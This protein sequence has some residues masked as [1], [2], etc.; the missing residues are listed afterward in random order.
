M[1]IMNE[2]KTAPEIVA[3]GDVEVVSYTTQVVAGTN[4]KISLKHAAGMS[5]V[6]VFKALPHAGEGEAVKVVS[7]THVATKKNVDQASGAAVLL[8]Y[9]RGDPAAGLKFEPAHTKIREPEDGE[10]RVRTIFFSLWSLRSF[11]LRVKLRY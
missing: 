10:A 7:I 1:A 11:V 8:S 3:L 6:K 2:I 9:K 4:Y 5:E